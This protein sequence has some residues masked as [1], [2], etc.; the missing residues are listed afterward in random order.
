[1]ALPPIDQTSRSKQPDAAMGG[2]LGVSGVFSG[3]LAAPT[4]ACASREMAAR[5]SLNPVTDFPHTL[6]WKAL[7]APADRLHAEASQIAL[8]ESLSHRFTVATVTSTV[9]P[10]GI[11]RVTTR[12]AELA[13]SLNCDGT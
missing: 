8:C 12:S 5:P 11:D 10:F 7:T 1:M 4:D 9:P 6:G 13:R 3:I 2:T